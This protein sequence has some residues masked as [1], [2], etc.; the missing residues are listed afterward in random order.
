MK[1]SLIISYNYPPVIGGI[2]TYAFELI[3]YFD[4]NYKDYYEFIYNKTLKPLSGI[5]RGVSFV[6]FILRTLLRIIFK[7]YDVIHIT[8]FNLWFIG[9][10]YSLIHRQTKIVLNLWGLELVYKSKKGILPII[11]NFLVPINLISNLSSFEFMVSSNASKDL[12]T[13]N[14]FNERKLHYIPLGTRI[15]NVENKFNASEEYVFFAGRIT[16]RKGLNWFV[17]NVLNEFPDLKLKFVGP[18]VDRKEYENIMKSKQVEYLGVVSEKDLI[19]LRHGSLAVII[20]NTKDKENPDFEAFCFVTIE[21]VAS[22][23]IVLASNYQGL[24]DSLLNGIL[25]F[26]AEPSDKESWVQKLKEVL[27]IEKEER[28]IIIEDRLEILKQKFMWQK[29]F[30]DTYQLHRKLIEK[31]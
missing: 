5:Y 23:A 6:I 7:K 15:F 25:G 2:E 31:K 11:Y 1:K 18:I 26:L 3:K 16:P 13:K 10:I 27:A 21:S 19:K 4:S 28:N 17:H 22:K 30:E 14:G 29:I 20:P 8:N 12:A 9:F 24:S